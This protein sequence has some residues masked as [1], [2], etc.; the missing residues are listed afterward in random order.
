MI[1]VR[2]GEQGLGQDL[3]GICHAVRGKYMSCG[4]QRHNRQGKLIMINLMTCLRANRCCELDNMQAPR[5]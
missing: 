5:L 2:Q 3:Q 1:L 4:V